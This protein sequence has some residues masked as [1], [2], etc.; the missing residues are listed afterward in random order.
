MPPIQPAW[1]ALNP[2]AARISGSTAAKVA[3]GTQFAIRPKASSAV[4]LPLRVL[5]AITDMHQIRLKPAHCQ[6]QSLRRAPNNLDRT[7]R[8]AMKPR[9]PAVSANTTTPW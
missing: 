3:I 5:S 8:I 7:G 9:R 1:L 6:R 2:H 4:A